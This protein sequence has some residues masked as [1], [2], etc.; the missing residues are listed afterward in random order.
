MVQRVMPILP[1]YP[2]TFAPYE[3]PEIAIAVVIEG[4]GSGGST[5]PVASAIMEYY[6]STNEYQ[7]STQ[8][9]GSLLK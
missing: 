2:L 5:A 1:K 7:D 6:F 3:N 4:A 9:E 8:K